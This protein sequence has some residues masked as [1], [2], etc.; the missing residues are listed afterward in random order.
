[1]HHI[2]SREQQIEPSILLY[3]NETLKLV[4][5]SDYKKNSKNYKGYHVV[6]TTDNKNFIIPSDKGKFNNDIPGIER[7]TIKIEEKKFNYITLPVRVNNKNFNLSI[8]GNK[9]IGVLSVIY[10]NSQQ[11][12]PI[13]LTDFDT[14]LLFNTPSNSIPENSSNK[15]SE[16]VAKSEETKKEV[17]Q[18]VEESQTTTQAKNTLQKKTTTVENKPQDKPSVEENKTVIEEKPQEQP[19]VKNDCR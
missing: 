6:C 2:I 15:S 12:K 3:N 4:K 19:V 17:Q 7:G 11:S 14:S 16:T 5:C 9:E 8:Y 10:T 18:V 13:W 1:M